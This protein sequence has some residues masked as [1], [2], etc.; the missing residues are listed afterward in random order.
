[1][2]AVPG[3]LAGQPGHGVDRTKL[4]SGVEGL[5][6][7]FKAFVSA[8]WIKEAMESWGEDLV[9]FIHRITIKWLDYDRN[10]SAPGVLGTLV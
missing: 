8:F 2:R 1:M 7:L 3:A 6:R 5:G 9:S 4:T 10:Y